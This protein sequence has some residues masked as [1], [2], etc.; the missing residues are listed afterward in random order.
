MPALKTI[1]HQP[2]SE[3]WNLLDHL[4]LLTRGS[5]IYSGPVAEGLP[6]FE[7]NGYKLP[8]FVNPFDFVID[9]AAVDVRSQESETLSLTRVDALKRA[10][11]MNQSGAI[12]KAPETASTNKRTRAREGVLLECFLL[13]LQQVRIL[14][15]R[16]WT[17]TCRDPLGLVASITEALSMGIMSGWIFLHL[18]TD[19]A[20]IR[21]RQGA[22]YS[23]S[24][25]QGYL[26]LL[27]ETY[28]LTTDIVVFDRERTEGVVSVLGF[29]SSR[30]IARLLIE[31]LP[32]PFL[33]SVIFY[34]MAGFR[35]DPIQF[36]N[37]FAVVL[38]LHYIAVNL[39][40]VCVAV[41]RNFLI[42]SLVANLAFTL[43]TLGCG[44]FVNTNNIA[45]WLQWTKWTAYV[46]CYQQKR[47]LII[48]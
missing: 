25:L 48:L 6:Y 8:P 1:V 35:S 9:L 15:R 19:L 12:E 3:I 26:V 46:V 14:T 32:V 36:F 41:S 21:S 22:L 5:L 29:I 28:R 24:A 18:G 45:I 20:G 44:F 17:V 37:F 33:Y 2:R 4:I 39:A 40:T 31:D 7:Q 23:A 11:S 42:A 10:W 13:L 27:F 30:R 38:L 43:Q 47:H 34:F 16:T